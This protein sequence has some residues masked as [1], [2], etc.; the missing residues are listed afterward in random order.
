MITLCIS[1]VLTILL[2]LLFVSLLFCGEDSLT[3]TCGII[4]IV[5]M[6]AAALWSNYFTNRSWENWLNKHGRAE[7]IQRTDVNDFPYLE[8]QMV[9]PVVDTPHQNTTKE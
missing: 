6:L 3:I 5:L 8:F 7:F 4:G 9:P 1:G 2:I